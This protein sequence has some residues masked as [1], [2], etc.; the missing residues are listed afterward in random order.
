MHRGGGDLLRQL[1]A[2]A[3]S[4]SELTLRQKRLSEIEAKVLK[5]ILPVSKLLSP[6]SHAYLLII[7]YKC[8]TCHV[9]IQISELLPLQ[10]KYND[11]KK[12]LALKSNELSLFQSRVE[13]NEHHKVP[14]YS[15]FII[16]TICFFVSL[17][18]V[19]VL[20]EVA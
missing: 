2:L 4:E 1:H 8:L 11:L 9:H 17:N 10:R 15:E 16:F 20:C 14:P 13:Q 3:Q 5:L 18:F 7:C 12:Q 19:Y 6:T